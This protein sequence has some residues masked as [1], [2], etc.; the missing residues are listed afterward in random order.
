[1]IVLSYLVLGAAAGLL[2]GLFGLG[3][4][5]I[6]VPVLIFSFTLMG[7]SPETLTHLAVGTSLATI[8]ITS[9]SSV[10]VHHKKRAVDWPLVKQLT[11][12]IVL[13][14]FIGAYTADFISG[15]MLQKLIG[16]YA[17]IVAAQ[18]GFNLKPKADRSLPGK[19][20][21][22]FV[23]GIIGSVSALFGIGGGSLTVPYLSWCSV[24]MPRAVATSSATGL[25][26]AIAGTLGYLVSGWQNS[27]LPEGSVGY[28][29]VPAWIGI[30]L[31]S[32]L[33][34]KFGA[35]LAHSLPPLLMK[36]LFAVVLCLV[37]VKFLLLS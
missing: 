29:F 22:T 33:F 27:A 21:Q 11:L 28:V 6:I 5:I 25:P 26:I 16:I 9:L 17:L 20:G 10:W 2:A 35:R 12:G 34:A 30:V 4:G 23:G 19:V 1:M 13:G 15:P 7:F 24:T 36:R 37:G 18:M 3:G 32:A 31:T 8:I 14:T